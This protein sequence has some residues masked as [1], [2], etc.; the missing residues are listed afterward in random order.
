MPKRTFILLLGFLSA[1]PHAYTQTIACQTI[2]G[3]WT[4]DD[5][6]QEFTLV[7]EGSSVTG[8]M[9]WPA[10]T[11]VSIW[12]I[13]GSAGGGAFS[14]TATNQG[15]SN[16][17]GG[18]TITFSGT[19]GQP[20]CNYVYGYQ[21]DA[22]GTWY[23]FGVENAYPTTEP[24]LSPNWVAKAVDVPTS[25]TTEIPPPAAWNPT[26]GGAPLEERLGIKR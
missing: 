11:G 1:S 24:P 23:D 3:N 8:N 2:Q 16:F 21:Q 4:N 19:I 7:Q 26:T 25:E 6:G 18:A 17:F 9:T 22:D 20:G 12:P 14:F 10:C 5:G 13:T 15:C